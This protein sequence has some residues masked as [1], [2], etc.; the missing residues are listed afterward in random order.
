MLSNLQRAQRRR[1]YERAS[2]VEDTPSTQAVT[3]PTTPE[4]PK[5][6][7]FHFY[8]SKTTRSSFDNGAKSNSPKVFHFCRRQMSEPVPLVLDKK[9]V[10]SYQEKENKAKETKTSDTKTTTTAK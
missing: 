9:K 5:V 4:T 6:E 7:G 2:S 8:S 3:P 1:R 10:V